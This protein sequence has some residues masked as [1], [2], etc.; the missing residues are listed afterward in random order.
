MAY[1]IAPDDIVST[2]AE[3][4]GNARPPL[5]VLEPL[6]EYLDAAGL[7]SGE[8]HVTPVGDG[9]SNVTYLIEREGAELILR[10][11]PRPPVAPSAHDVMREARVL[12]ALEDTPVRAPRVLAAC[13]QESV[14]GSPFYVME[15]MVGE[16]I[17]EALPQALE[18][19]AERRRIG[20]EL[21]DALVELH[22]V[23]WGA[24]GLEGFGKP[25]GY[26]ERQVRRFLG[27]WEKNKTRELEQVERLGSWLAEHLP[28]SPPA[29]IVHGDY[30]LGNTMFASRAPAELVAIFDW[31][32]TTIGD[33]LADVGYLLMWWAEP[34]DPPHPLGLPTLSE[35]PGFCTRAE[36]V[37]RYQ[38]RSGRPVG[39]LHWY[40]VLAVWKMLVIVEGNYKRA[41]AGATDDPYQL[42]HGEHVLALGEIASAIAF[43]P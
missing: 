15:R 32:M 36:I 19:I 34:G 11:P 3:A 26:L 2:A 1:P 28:S 7:G 35:Q 29:T 30:R 17:E 6:A 23:D 18:P 9:H 24:V 40:M 12:R 8:L 16:V 41:L 31:E 13:A 42:A 33:P 38:E 14:I 43:G 4:D 21:V 25:S 20:E 37:A 5:L 27:L 22:A 39:E 10:R